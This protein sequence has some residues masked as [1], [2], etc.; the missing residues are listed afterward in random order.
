MPPIYS[1][2]VLSGVRWFSYDS[3]DDKMNAIAC[4]RLRNVRMDITAER[5]VILATVT[6]GS[7]NERFGV[8]FFKSE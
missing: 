2:M 6:Q 5:M 8:K 4:G 3:R 7:K 1:V